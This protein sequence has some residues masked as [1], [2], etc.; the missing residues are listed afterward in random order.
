MN[1]SELSEA[2][3]SGERVYGTCSTSTSPLWPRAI[4][5]SGVD[6]VFIDTEHT[7]IDRPT[8]AWMCQT[9][10]ALDIA[11]LVRIPMP[12]PYHASMVIDGGAAGVIAPYVETPDEVKALRGAV[13]FGPLKGKRL[14]DFLEGREN[15]DDETIAYLRDRNAGNVLAVNIESQAALDNL[16]DILAV[17]DLDALLIG[18]HDLS[19][20]LGLPEQYTH[21][22]FLAAVSTVIRKARARDVGVGIHY[23]WGM[24]LELVWAKEGANFIV[25]SSD[26][27]LATSALRAD[28]IRF[29]AEL[30]DAAHSANSEG[31]VTI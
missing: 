13:K 5:A 24:D 31:D 11:P 25:H 9:Y 20:N 8:L 28:L 4:A 15:L 10:R 16:D 17:P 14:D 18:P 27:S 7:P 23:S 26:I 6:F 29:R 21:P 19:I 3:R 1:C 12:D 30:G 22:E 2:L